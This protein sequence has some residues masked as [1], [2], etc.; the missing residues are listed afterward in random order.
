MVKLHNFFVQNLRF[1]ASIF[2][3]KNAFFSNKIAYQYNSRVGD[4]FDGDAVFWNA[5]LGLQLWNNKGTLTL[6]GYDVLGKNNGFRRTVTENYIQDVDNRI[7]D[8]YFML[9]F[10]FKF[11]RIAGQNMN[12]RP[13]GQGRGMGGGRRSGGG[14]RRR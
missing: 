14:M 9:T 2:F 5:G 1:D 4:E 6:V 3:L 10:V 8:Q 13:K 12:E 11:G 7:L